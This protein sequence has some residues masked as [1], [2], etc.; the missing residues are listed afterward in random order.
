M[1]GFHSVMAGSSS[2]FDNVGRAGPGANRSAAVPSGGFTLVELLVVIGIIALLISILLP[3]LGKARAAAQQVSCQS[4]LHQLY[5]SNLIYASQNKEYL[6]AP[7]VNLT[8]GNGSPYSMT[9]KDVADAPFLWYNAFSIMN[10]GKPYGPLPNVPSQDVFPANSVW[11][12]YR[13]GNFGRSMLTCPAVGADTQRRTYA[14][15]GC[16]NQQWLEQLLQRPVQ[17]APPSVLRCHAEQQRWN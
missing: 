14:M 4:N 13:N 1:G 15:N 9:E 2:P 16:L 11:D 3:S 10:G 12:K 6:A 5:L 7:S 8:A 17:P